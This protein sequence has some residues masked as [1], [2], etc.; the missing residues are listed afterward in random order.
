MICRVSALLCTSRP[1]CLSAARSSR[2]LRNPLLFASNSP[3]AADTYTKPSGCLST[4]VVELWPLQK[5]LR[6]FY[7][8]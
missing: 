4:A 5:W 2:T 3:N 7:S 6:E 8:K 1:K